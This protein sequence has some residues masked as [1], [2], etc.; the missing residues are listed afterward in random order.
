MASL[1]ASIV[2]KTTAT[3]EK[4]SSLASLAGY[5]SRTLASEIIQSTKLKAEYLTGFFV[6]T[7]SKIETVNIAETLTR[8]F[9]KNVQDQV[10]LTD[11]VDNINFGKNPTDQINIL[12]TVNNSVGKANS[13]Q[14]NVSELISN[15]LEK[16]SAD[17]ITLTDSDDVQFGKNPV[18][19]LDLT[20]STQV[21]LTK[22]SVDTLNLGDNFDRTVAFFRESTDQFNVNDNFDRIV[23]FFRDF[24]DQVNLTDDVNGAAVDDD[25]VTSFFKNTGDQLNLIDDLSRDVAFFREAVD[26]TNISE[27]DV[28]D[29]NKNVSDQ[30]NVTDDINGAAVDDDQVASFFKNTGDQF[31]L[32]DSFDRT[33]QFSRD[34]TD[35][36]NITDPLQ[37]VFSKDFLDTTQVSDTAFVEMF[38]SVGLTDGL[39]VTDDINGAAVDDDQVVTLFKV[40]TE[41]VNLSDELYV[42]LLFERT[43]LDQI[44][45]SN[46]GTILNQNYIN[47]PDYFLEDYVGVSR[48]IT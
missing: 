31:N 22:A 13:D 18:D 2:S 15:G 30:V 37:I 29:F 14:L 39:N 19:I 6:I 10:S 25:Q 45:I 24:T 33:V 7:F 4:V 35:I 41:Q 1:L 23:Q 28:V 17:A 21:D 16:I 40:S 47:G 3:I 38:F 44:S 12:E 9:G 20:E 8:L 27:S 5:R 42:T 34:F 11:S 43:P 32:V 48:T 36:L 26:Q 46:S